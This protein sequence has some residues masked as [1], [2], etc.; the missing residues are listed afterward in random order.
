MVGYSVP[1]ARNKGS[2]RS[3]NSESW[4][5]EVFETWSRKASRDRHQIPNVLPVQ[6]VFCML[7]SSACVHPCQVP[8]T[9]A[10]V[11]PLAD[12]QW[13]GETVAVSHS[14]SHVSHTKV[15]CDDSITCFL[16]ENESKSNVTC[17]GR[18][19]RNCKSQPARSGRGQTC[20]D[21]I[22]NRVR[23]PCR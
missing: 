21:A 9:A 1:P 11:D 22:H 4:Q 23:R 8:V 6:A 10:H 14:S 18:V 2:W 13:Q 15:Q 5:G 12:N 19:C 7:M 3:P 20:K 17:I 16:I